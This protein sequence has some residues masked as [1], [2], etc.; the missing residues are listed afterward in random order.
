MSRR[1]FLAACT[2]LAAAPWA[3]AQ[4]GRHYRLGWVATSANTF[5]EPYGQA[6]GRRLAELGFVEG[7]NLT[8]DRRHAENRVEN[9]AKVGAA[10]AKNRYDAMFAAGP[11]ATLAA[12]TQASRDAPIIVIAI[13][14]DPLTTGDFSA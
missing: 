6:I 14:F 11:E 8:I 13:D 9:F 2:A 3:R 10:M 7:R 4:Q 12:A 1:R 5:R